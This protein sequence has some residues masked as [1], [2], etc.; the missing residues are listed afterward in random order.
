M[1]LG[2]VCGLCLSRR[3]S[4][5]DGNRA[6]VV[7]AYLEANR[8]IDQCHERMVGTHVDV[9]TRME[10]CATLTHDDVASLTSLSAPNFH[11]KSLRSRLTT[12]L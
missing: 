11:T 9:L 2:C 12:V 5:N 7:T 10:L 4:R 6:L 3:N 1:V 8:T